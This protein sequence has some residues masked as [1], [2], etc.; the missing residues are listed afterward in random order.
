MTPTRI[1]ELAHKILHLD[2]TPHELAKAFGVGVFVA[3]TPTIGF[4]TATVLI[5]AW[6]FGLN[7]AVALTGTFVNNPWTMAFA[8]IGPT[9]V[10]AVAMRKMGFHVPPLNYDEFS[11]RFMYVNDQYTLWQREFWITL[12]DVF[13]PYL[14]A[15]FSGT[16]V[17]AVV[18]GILAYFVSYFGIKYY[19]IEKAKIREKIKGR[20]KK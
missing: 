9:W 18:A 1:R 16:M 5:L 3:F 15:F 7:K 17:A 8:Y 4:H 12:S 6:V 11:A 10:A 20:V 2:E 13:S 19:R 14:I